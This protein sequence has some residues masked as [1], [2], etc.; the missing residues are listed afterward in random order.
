MKKLQNTTVGTYRNDFGSDE[1]LALNLKFGHVMENIIMARFDKHLHK[2]HGITAYIEHTGCGPDG[3]LM[4][5]GQQ[6][7]EADFKVNGVK[8]EV[9]TKQGLSLTQIELKKSN[10]YSYIKQGAYVLYAIGC[11]NQDTT[12]F[13][14][15]S[16]EQL[17][18]AYWTAPTRTL[19]KW[20]EC[21]MLDVTQFDWVK[22]E[23]LEPNHP[24]FDELTE[25]EEAMKKYHKR[26]LQYKQ[27][28]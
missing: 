3:E 20:K 17:K 11:R 28:V 25:V 4:E 22:L 2:H 16:P 8:V 1:L 5:E 6:S 15:I 19:F 21:L 10:V 24:L 12:L 13:T 7:S 18:E 27:A 26:N 23:N 14:L 9:K